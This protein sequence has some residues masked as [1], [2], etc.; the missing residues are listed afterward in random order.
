MKAFTYQI[1]MICSLCVT[2]FCLTGPMVAAQVPEK[3]YAKFDFIPGE[4]VLFEDDFKTEQADE[5]PSYWIITGG[6]VE[7]SK[8]NGELVMGFLDKS[9]AAMPRMKGWMNYGDRV[10]FEFDYLWRHNQK[11]WEQA[12]REGNTSGGD[13]INIRFANNKDYYESNEAKN[14]LGDL[15]EDLYIKSGGTVQFREFKGEYTSGEKVSGLEGLFADLNDK[16]VHVSIAIND[17]SLKVYLNSERVLNAQ[18]NEGKALAFQFMTTGSSSE[19]GS[20]V[21]IKN[22]RIAKG[23]ADPYKQLTADGR[24]IARGINFDVGKA[25]IKPESLGMFNAL[26]KMMKEHPELKFEVGG[27]TDSDGDDA[28]NMKLSQDR[29]A[30]VREKLISMGIDPGRL[31]SQGYGETKPISPNTTPE[32]KANNR[33]VELLKK[34]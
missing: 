13:G 26:V 30:A 12:W 14:Q 32:G 21:F 22:V 17:R 19:Y 8:V 28:L 34:Q 9:P 24:L 6:K 5:I 33:R 15:Y 20:Q 3:A 16:W 1:N 7:V 23:G 18:I 25:T 10:T 2:V 11:S 4:Q 27:H 31:T 29:A